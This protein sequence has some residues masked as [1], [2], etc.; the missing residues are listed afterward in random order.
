[1]AL[2]PRQ[3]ETFWPLYREYRNEMARVNDRYVKLLVTYA[4]NY[5]ASRTSSRPGCSRVPGH[6]EGPQCRQARY[7]RGRPPV[8]EG[9]DAERKEV[10]IPNVVLAGVTIRRVSVSHPP[11][12]QRAG[13][14]RLGRSAER[15][16]GVA[17]ATAAETH[18]DRLGQ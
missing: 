12:G 7:V 15:G 16:D 18:R 4:D 2:D 11:S 14:A 1:M 5:D 8:H 13:R 3:A 17:G 9:R 6:R 10:A